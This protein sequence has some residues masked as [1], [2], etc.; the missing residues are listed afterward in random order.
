MKYTLIIFSIFLTAAFT[1]CDPE[2]VNLNQKKYNDTIDTVW[3]T[4]S[5]VNITLKNTTITASKKTVII[6]GTTATITKPGNY[7]I[8]GTL[9]NGQIIV[10]TN[11]EGRVRLIFNNISITNSTTSPLFIANAQRTIIVLQKNSVNTLTDGNNY[12]V[13]PDSLNAPIFSKDDLAIFGDGILNVNGNYK[14]GITSRDELDILSGTI[15]VN[16]VTT[17]IR[18]KDNLRIENGT[19]NI[20]CGGDALKAD[21]DSLQSTGFVNI[22]NGVFKIVTASGDGITAS[23]VTRIENGNYDIKT[24]GGS[25]NTFDPLAA[26]TKGIKGTEGTI[27]NGGTFLINSSDNCIHSSKKVEISGGN[28]TIYTGN[29]AIKADSM[30]TINNG[31]FDIKEAFKGISSY[32]LKIHGGNITVKSRNDCMKATLGENL[33]ANDGSSIEIGGGTLLLSTEKGDA[34]DSNGSINMTGGTLVLQGSQTVPDDA[35]S[36]R[37]TFTISGGN[38]VAAGAG[39][40]TP[41]TGTQQISVLIRFRTYLAPGTLICIQD[42][43][44]V[45]VIIFKIQRYALNTLF[46]TSKLTTGK[47][48]NIFTGGSV[49]GTEQNG[50]YTEGIYA[51]GTK[52]GSFTLNAG[53]NSVFL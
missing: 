30:L 20:N 38:V 29:R 19:F 16:S 37:S 46:S 14:G 47:T 36:Y 25:E 32:R 42:E 11:E 33:T 50:F 41:T 49:S 21:N 40:L 24:G 39:T 22:K 44:N 17:G 10:N 23:N 35:I 43:N 31:N 52:R 26:S 7:K 5:V 51:P 3:D 2:N 48:Y 34:L 1:A 53:H 4:T 12:T 27:I 28:F 13:T 9:A 6:S 18:G 15:N 8:S 45:S